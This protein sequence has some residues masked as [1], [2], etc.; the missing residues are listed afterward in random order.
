MNDVKYVSIY[1][2]HR[3]GV[4]LHHTSIKHIYSRGRWRGALVRILANDAD[5]A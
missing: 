3:K 1:Q 2:F 5:V 4:I